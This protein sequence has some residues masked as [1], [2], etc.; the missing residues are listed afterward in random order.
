MRP[1]DLQFNMDDVASLPNTQT[2]ERRYALVDLAQL[3][4]AQQSMLREARSAAIVC[5]F[6]YD[7]VLQRQ[8]DIGAALVD[9]S[10]ADNPSHDM[11]TFFISIIESERVTAQTSWLISAVGPD[12]LS[13]HLARY[14]KVAL[15]DKRRALL[16]F[17]DAWL[18][19]RFVRVLSPVQWADFTRLVSQ[20]RLVQLD[21]TW[22][23]V[24]KRPERFA[25]GEGDAP[26]AQPGAAWPMS[27]LQHQMLVYAGLPGQVMRRYFD[28][29][30]HRAQTRTRAEVYVEGLRT[31]RE[32]A[33]HG[34]VAIDDLEAIMMIGLLNGPAFV[35]LPAVREQFASLDSGED[36]QQVLTRLA[37][38]CA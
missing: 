4:P 15:P 6:E 19:P 29:Q 25:V 9:L 16:R 18:L 30:P 35:D 7:P 27:E 37:T 38:I 33:V 23:D 10:E 8:R 22:V 12:A 24:C 28:E 1:Q 31:M 17:Y 20:W 34:V 2:G 26:S 14:L 21:G 11:H 5:L 36:F 13:R 3:S 32:A